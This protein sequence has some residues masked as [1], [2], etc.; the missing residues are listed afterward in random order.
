MNT[1][2]DEMLKS[3]KYIILIILKFIG[4]LLSVTGIIL[5]YFKMFIYKYKLIN[6]YLYLLI[7]LYIYLVLT[8]HEPLRLESAPPY[9]FLDILSS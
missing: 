8:I 6:K 4:T 7:I 9:I 5:I 1:I 3:I 2:K